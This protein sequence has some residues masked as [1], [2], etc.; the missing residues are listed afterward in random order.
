MSTRLPLLALIIGFFAS[1]APAQFA[2]TT[3]IGGGVTGSIATNSPGS[4][5]VVGGG[6]DIWDTADECTFH[7]SPVSGDFDVKARVQSLQPTARWTKAGLMLR[8]STDG[9]S[10]MA[11]VRVTPPAVPTGNGG[12][13]ANDVRLSYRTGIPGNGANGGQHEDGT[14]TPAYPNAWIRLQRQGSVLTAY[15]STNGTIWTT[16]GTQ[17]TVTWQIAGLPT[18]LATNVLLGLAVSRHSGPTLTATAEFRNYTDTTPFAP[19]I[20]QQPTNTIVVA[21]RPVTF[22]VGLRGFDPNWSF[23]WRRGATNIPGATAQ[24]YTI[25][26]TVTNDTGSQFSVRVTNSLGSVLSASAVL[27][28]TTAPRLDAISS[29]GHPNA[30]Y[31]V[32]S[33]PMGPSA[34]V[35][36]NYLVNNSVVVFSAAYAANQSTIRLDTSSLLEGTNYTVTI[37]NVRDQS[38]PSLLILPNP[39][40]ASFIHGKGYE[41]FRIT[42]QRYDSIGGGTSVSDLLNASRYPN[43]PTI[44]THPALFEIPSN[45]GDSYGSQLSGYYIAPVTG[46]HKF[47][48]S[49]DDQGATFLAVDANPAHQA[50]IALEPQ[51]GGSRAFT[52]AGHDVNGGRG[53]PPSNGSADIL[54]TAGQRVYLA[55]IFKEGNAS[56]NL[57][58][59][60]TIDDPAPPPNGAPPISESNFMPARN[61]GGVTFFT[62]GP[63]F[64]TT[65]PADQTVFVG[66][67]ATFA[68]TVDGTPPYTVQWFSNSVA[69]AGA[70]NLT[71]TTPAAGA[72][73]D[74][75]RFQVTVNNEFSSATSSNATLAVL[76]N[77]QV[78]AASSRGNPNAVYVTF[79]KPVAL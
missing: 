41:G 39:T 47:W 36:G 22:R 49:S 29:R 28:V 20:T 10:R 45:V 79:N 4:Y 14:N 31:L 13:G 5:T 64:F 8:E 58:V 37:S 26:S 42:H 27:T 73:D 19:L 77:P 2:Q 61:F 35:A 6:Y 71:Y 9:D 25:A 17:D 72:A 76:Q 56:D 15:S 34:L 50:Q 7:Y 60:V 46:N 59:A 40:T 21:G 44:V 16:L 38:V 53:D 43:D 33:E 51:W 65:Q 69:L 32:F 23:Q 57:A 66:Q 11:F 3:R 78:L 52:D 67:T 75:T 54:L 30:I 1:P 12:N 68:A 48:M 24:S 18:P 62:L 70:T 74:G 55:A 63:V